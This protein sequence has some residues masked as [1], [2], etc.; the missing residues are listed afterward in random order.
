[1]VVAGN[2]PEIEAL[3]RIFLR[4]Q[5]SKECTVI[6]LFLQRVSLIAIS[7]YVQKMFAA[8]SLHHGP[9]VQ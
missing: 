9:A 5:I 7:S 6:R 3:T 4:L 1:M 8:V 2:D